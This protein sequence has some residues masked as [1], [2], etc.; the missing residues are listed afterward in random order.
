MKTIFNQLLVP[1]REDPVQLVKKLTDS[2]TD[3]AMKDRTYRSQ[4]KYDGLYGLHTDNMMFS[5]SGKELHNVKFKREKHSGLCVIGE[6]FN[7]F[8]DCHD[9][10]GLMQPNRKEPP[11]EREVGLLSHTKFYIHDC[12]SKTHLV[13][14]RCDVPYYQRYHHLWHLES[15]GHFPEGFLLVGNEDALTGLQLKN[16]LSNID[17]RIKRD[18]IEGM[19]YKDPSA[20]WTAGSRSNDYLKRVRM[21]DLDLVCTGMQ[22]GQNGKRAGVPT[23]LLFRWRGG[24]EIKADLGIGWTDERRIELLSNSPVGKVYRVYAMK[25]SKNGYLRNP[26][27]GEQRIDKSSA[28]ADF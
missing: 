15:L 18:G 25:Y 10:T 4:V 16:D 11:T 28:T 23:N 24:E 1:P 9:L 21:I 27:V 14:G 26:K 6:I 20:I 19:V 12:I 13:S 7:P 5:R 17:A 22:I 2:V 8:L 3:K